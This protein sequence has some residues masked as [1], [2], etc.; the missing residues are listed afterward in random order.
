MTMAMELISANLYASEFGNEKKS[1]N[2]RMIKFRV[3]YLNLL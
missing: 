2:I 1:N 3:H